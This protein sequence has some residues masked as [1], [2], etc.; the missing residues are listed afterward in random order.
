MK[1]GG[2]WIFVVKI[3]REV[4]NCSAMIANT[5]LVNLVNFCE[6]AHNIRQWDKKEKKKEKRKKGPKHSQGMN[7]QTKLNHKSWIY[8]TLEQ[9]D[10][11]KIPDTRLW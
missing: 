1:M 10:T 8:E 3:V 4:T 2:W 6:V 9:C 5:E 7:I 11:H